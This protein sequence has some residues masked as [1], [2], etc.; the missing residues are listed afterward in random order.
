M[1]KEAAEEGFT[2][3]AEMF[4]NIAEVEAVHEKRYRDFAKNLEEGHVFLKDGKV[5]W[6]CRNC[7]AIYECVEAPEICPVCKHKQAHFEIQ[8]KNW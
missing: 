4:S 3:L 8:A 5:F 7:G 1:A 6:K 2:E